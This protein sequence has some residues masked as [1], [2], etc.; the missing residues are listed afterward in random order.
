MHFMSILTLRNPYKLRVFH[1]SKISNLSKIQPSEVILMHERKGKGY[2]GGSGT[3][4]AN[5]QII[6]NPTDWTFYDLYEFSFMNEQ[7]CTV[8]VNGSNPIPCPANVGFEISENDAPLTS[9]VIIESGIAFVWRGK[10]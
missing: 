1:L 10:Y 3:S 5:Q 8:R 2:D 7:A 4:T 9:F 6:I